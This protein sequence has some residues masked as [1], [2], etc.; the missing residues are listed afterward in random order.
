VRL[1]K[2]SFIA[3]LFMNLVLNCF[4]VGEQLDVSCITQFD[5]DT[6]FVAYDSELLSQCS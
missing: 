3:L 2:L 6:V 4:A 1:K 5:N